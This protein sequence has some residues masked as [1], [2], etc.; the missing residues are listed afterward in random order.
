MRP[1][2]GAAPVESYHQDCCYCHSAKGCEGTVL[3]R[4]E[5]LAMSERSRKSQTEEGWLSSE[6]QSRCVEEETSLGE[7]SQEEVWARGG[8]SRISGSIEARLR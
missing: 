3:R 8:G 1:S 7:R 4:K 6:A 5:N 2:S